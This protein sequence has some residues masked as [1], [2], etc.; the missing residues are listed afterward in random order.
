[1]TYP[2]PAGWKLVPEDATFAMSSALR[3][4]FEKHRILHGMPHAPG[5]SVHAIWKTLLGAAPALPQEE[6]K[7]AQAAKPAPELPRYPAPSRLSAEELRERKIMAEHEEGKTKGVQMAWSDPQL[8][9]H[10]T[11]RPTPTMEERMDRLTTALKIAQEETISTIKQESEKTLAHLL[12]AMEKA[13]APRPQETV[14]D[15]LAR[16][17]HPSFK[18][19]VSVRIWAPIEHAPKDGRP[20]WVR[21]FNHGDPVKGVHCTWA[22]WDGAEGKWYEAGTVGAQLLYLTHYM[23]GADR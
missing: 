13:R 8:A 7:E 9:P 22:Y 12:A 17:V 16:R 1:M 2:V 20:A 21:G 6:R 10:Q 23:P 4:A 15:V 3:D 11:A 18:N 19:P 14:E 5:L